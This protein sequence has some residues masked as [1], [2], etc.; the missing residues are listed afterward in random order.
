MGDTGLNGR[1][2]IRF[3]N[4]TEII[5]GRAKSKIHHV[6]LALKVVGFPIFIENSK[7]NF[8][9]RFCNSNIFWD[10]LNNLPDNCY[11]GK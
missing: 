3:E 9:G 6:G 8:K 1:G 10:F 5:I 2:K 11:I 7:V 4:I